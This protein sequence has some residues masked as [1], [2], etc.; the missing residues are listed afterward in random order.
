M[1][2]PH[3]VSSPQH[4]SV[5]YHEYTA[6]NHHAASQDPKT[7]VG[8]LAELEDLIAGRLTWLWA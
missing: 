6:T 3:H 5:L 2:T 7:R 8:K 1:V 4:I